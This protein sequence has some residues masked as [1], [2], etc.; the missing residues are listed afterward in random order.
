MAAAASSQP[1]VQHGDDEGSD[2]VAAETK[3]DVPAKDPAGSAAA[4]AAAAGDGGDGD[5]DATAED[6]SVAVAL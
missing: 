4:A 2:T 3:I 5:D 1:L 6:V